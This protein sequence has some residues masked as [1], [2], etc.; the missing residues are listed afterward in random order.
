VCNAIYNILSFLLSGEHLMTLVFSSYF[1]LVM[2]V[3]HK[4]E[5]PSQDDRW[6]YERNDEESTRLGR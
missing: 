1:F 2:P 4:D 6:V 3:D 5:Q